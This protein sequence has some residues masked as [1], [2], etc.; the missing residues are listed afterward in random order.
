MREKLE[1]M[2]KEELQVKAAVGL[3]S[4]QPEELEGLHCKTLPVLNCIYELGRGCAVV[5][6]QGSG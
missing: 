5:D 2:D 3:Q 1:A 6:T 4:N